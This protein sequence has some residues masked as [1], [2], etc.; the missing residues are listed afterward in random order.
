[1]LELQT[2]LA[3][4]VLRSVRQ[5][6]MQVVQGDV[7][8]KLDGA[9]PEVLGYTLKLRFAERSWVK[10]RCESCYY[11]ILHADKVVTGGKVFNF[12]NDKLRM[13]H[14][15]YY[16]QIGPCLNQTFGVIHS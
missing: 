1:M 11:Y 15:W 8:V 14:K 4:L 9:C 13:P 10:T 5:I 16:L 7:K 2:N 6:W 12:L 3:V